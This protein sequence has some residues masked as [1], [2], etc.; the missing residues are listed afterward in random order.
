MSKKLLSLTLSAL[1]AASS[2]SLSTAFAVK[3]EPASSEPGSTPPTAS[4]GVIMNVSSVPFTVAC[5]SSNS[6]NKADNGSKKSNDSDSDSE[7]SD[8]CEPSKSKKRSRRHRKDG[9]ALSKKRRKSSDSSSSSSDESSSDES[10]Y[11]SSKVAVPVAPLPLKA[12]EAPPAAAACNNLDQVFLEKYAYCQAHKDYSKPDLNMMTEDTGWALVNKELPD[13]CNVPGGTKTIGG[14][15]KYFRVFHQGRTY[16]M[17]LPT[18]GMVSSS[19]MSIENIK[20]FALD[21]TKWEF[22]YFGA[23]SLATYNTQYRNEGMVNSL[24]QYINIITPH[25]KDRGDRK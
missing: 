1:V 11:K 5:A 7:C 20:R 9:S 23:N 24:E 19:G 10:T 25:C 3:N 13:S 21:P 22:R 4:S 12:P 16:V 14:Y 6:D 2:A 8:H 15:N 17:L 18:F